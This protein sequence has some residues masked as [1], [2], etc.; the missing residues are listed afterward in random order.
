MSAF[1]PA[2]EGP[3]EEVLEVR[4][5]PRRARLELLEEPVDL[6]LT[7]R[8]EVVLRDRLGDVLEHRL[9]RLPHGL[10]PLLEEIL[11]GLRHGDLA[12]RLDALLH[13]LPGLVRDLRKRLVELL[14]VELEQQAPRW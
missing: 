11:G 10:A 5:E 1:A 2:A 8:G 3:H 13:R 6:G 14:V 12:E 4:L 9:G 7:H